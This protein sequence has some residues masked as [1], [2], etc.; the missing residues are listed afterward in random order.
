MP[1]TSYPSIITKP[2]PPG[3]VAG[4]PTCPLADDHP[5]NGEKCPVSPEPTLDTW[6]SKNGPGLLHSPNCGVG[7]GARAGEWRQ[8]RQTKKL[9]WIPMCHRA[10]VIGGKELKP[11]EPTES[12][13]IYSHVGQ[14]HHPSATARTQRWTTARSWQAGLC[15]RSV[16]R[17]AIAHPQLPRPT[18]RECGRSGLSESYF[19][20]LRIDSPSARPLSQA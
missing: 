17:A 1:G 9:L 13:R 6:S 3:P 11:D 4:S 19:E 16:C 12:V 2:P 8:A 14:W 5:L 18:V 20:L 7:Y 15:G 10:G